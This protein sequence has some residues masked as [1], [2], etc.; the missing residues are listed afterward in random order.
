MGAA[1]LSGVLES[2][3]RAQA[4]GDE[5]R[6]SRFIATVNSEGSAEGLRTRFAQYAD[7]FEVL[8]GDNVTAMQRA[9]IV[10]LAFKPYMVD[11][12]LRTR[13]VREAL[14]GKLVISVLVGSPP[15]KL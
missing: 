15:H 7:R 3:S 8:R 1:I 4:N 14:M 10:L 2:C 9:D 13:G 6:I 11:L 5:P 12:V